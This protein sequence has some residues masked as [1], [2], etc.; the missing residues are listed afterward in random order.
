MDVLAKRT[1]FNLTE[2]RRLKMRMGEVTITEA[3]LLAMAQ[4]VERSK[5]KIDLR[6]T[7]KSEATTGTDFEI[8]L[9]TRKGRVF[10]YSIQAK[11]IR[12][13]DGIYEYP[14]LGH[15]NAH[16]VQIDLLEQRAKRVGSYPVHLFFN[17]WDQPTIKAPTFPTGRSVELF[18]CAAV[19]TT[20]VRSVRNAIGKGNGINKVAR[21][22]AESMPWSDLFRVSV[23]AKSN[24]GRSGGA[25]GPGYED[26]PSGDS[27]GGIEILT[28]TDDRNPTRSISLTGRDFG[29]LEQRLERLGG[30]GFERRRPEG[31]PEDVVSARGKSRDLLPYEDEDIDT[32][33]FALVIEEE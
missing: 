8:W 12:L 1:W 19:Q 11:V 29:A 30:G 17:G 24:G 6:A 32:P 21:Y 10:G 28:P 5:L 4:L 13:R 31:I 15:K 26:S 23:Y 16:G 25:A 18:G 7:R 22:A 3:N 9:K 14:E 20:V 2:A 27:G 33:L